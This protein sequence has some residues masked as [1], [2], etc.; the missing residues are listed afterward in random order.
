MCFGGCSNRC[1]GYLPELAK[2]DSM[3]LKKYDMDD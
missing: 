2:A 1:T 3:S